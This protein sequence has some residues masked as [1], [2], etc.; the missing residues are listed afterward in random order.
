MKTILTFLLSIFTLIYGFSQTSLVGAWE[1]EIT[2]ENGE[3]IKA[4][5]IF[6]KNHQSM[7]LYKPTGEM[8]GT[9]GGTWN[10]EKDVLTETTE[11]DTFDSSQVGQT[12]K[13]K[14]QL[15]ETTL[16]F[17]EN[18][19]TLKRVDNGNPG[20][21]AG[22][23][24]FYSRNIPGSEMSREADNPRKTM[25]ILSGTRFQ[26][27]AYDTQTKEVFGSGGG[28][29]STKDG[30]YT[31]RIEF[32]A[33]DPTR[34]GMELEFNFDLNDNE[35]RHSGR[36]TKGDPIDETWKRRGIRF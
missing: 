33:K 11:F 35:W 34:S 22:A 5:V 6:S 30:K 1:G 7:V 13:T 28:T 21:L 27:I 18:G 26:W 12:I 17:P 24:L 3:T 19:F 8:I 36:S 14:I 32:F 16:N 23:W 31:E 15:T 20:K 25:K 10:L 2:D 4:A 9:Q 29:Y